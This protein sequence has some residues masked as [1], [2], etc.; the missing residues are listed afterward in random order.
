MKRKL[1]EGARRKA[2]IQAAYAA[3][4]KKGFE[5]L[6]LRAVAAKAG[7]DHS[8]LHHHFPT[9][10][11]LV[12]AVLD[13]ATEQFRPAPQPAGAPAATLHEH[14]QF[15]SRMMV[16]RP[17]LHIVLR[18]F[19]LHATRDPRVRAIIVES[20]KGWRERLVARIQ[21]A[22]REGVWPSHFDA[23]TGAELVIAL[24]KGVS[25]QPN[26]AADVLK[27][28]ERLLLAQPPLREAPRETRA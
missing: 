23:A 14:L 13:Y 26:S 18:E 12:A 1:S 24:I 25:F 27:L 16:E 28:F 17:E 6:R 11:D 9:K 22:E 10:R 20:E 15:L 4:G 2:L 21:L 8:T 3:I 7:I 5:G 19:D